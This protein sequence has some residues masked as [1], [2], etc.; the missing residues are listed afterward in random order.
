M[1]IIVVILA[2]ALIYYFY[3][4][5][6]SI[7]SFFNSD[8][9]SN[10]GTVSEDEIM[11]II[12]LADDGDSDAKSQLEQ[13]IESGQLD[14]NSKNAYRRKIYYPKAMQ[15]DAN[16]EYW[17]GWIASVI[18]ENALEALEW[19]TKAANHGNIE[20][21]HDLAFGYG[22][23]A[24]KPE[25]GFTGFGADSEKEMYWITK[26]AEAGNHRCQ[27]NLAVEYC[28]NRDYENGIKWYE[29]STESDDLSLKLW[30]YHALAGI[31]LGIHSRTQPFKDIARAKNLLLKI[32][33]YR[34]KYIQMYDDYET[35]Y[36]STISSLAL[37]YSK[38]YGDTHSRDDLVNAVYCYSISMFND[39]LDEAANE[40]KKLPY[41]PSA[42]Q[43]S[44][45]KRHAEQL[46][47]MPPFSE[48]DSI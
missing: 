1:W 6:G 37:L 10:N 35:L 30:G 33:E 32:F 20:A 12:E 38:E 41:S 48:K 47:F 14:Q 45:W 26:G 16:A 31:Y 15:G 3:N 23:Y 34:D 40:L 24:N 28:Y 22:E 11:K 5:G 43:Y 46:V 42:E 18:D 21:F 27:K 13:L 25:N 19:Y 8:N 39:W 17:M 4:N 9:Y 44:E 2:F 7:T 29:K 36:N